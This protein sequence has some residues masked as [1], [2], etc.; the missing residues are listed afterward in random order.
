MIFIAISNPLI[1]SFLG[2]AGL[3]R[4][5]QVSIFS[6][7]LSLNKIILLSI[8]NYLIQFKPSYYFTVGEPTIITRHFTHGLTPLL[9]STAPFLFLGLIVLLN[10]LDKR[11]FQF[12]LFFIF[13]YP[14]GGAL[15]A[16]APFTSRDIIG[17]IPA[18]LLISL[19]VYHA[20][21]YLNMHFK[22]ISYIFYVIVFSAFMLNLYSFI[23]FYFAVY[24]LYSSNF[25]G[26]QF[27]AK[28]IINYFFRHEKQYD[29][30]VMSPEFNAPEIFIKFYAPHDCNNCFI[31]TPNTL[32]NPKT[33]QLFALT[34]S[35]LASH[36]QYRFQDI[37]NIIYP[38]K[39]IAFEIGKIVQ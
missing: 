9:L 18:V 17:V 37:K 35:Y 10:S 22:K 11:V 8:H 38:N 2:S 4:F 25:W 30:L 3:A 7:H 24:P 32:Y 14:L 27:G 29:Q 1:I 5:S 16:Q 28:G 36:P 23:Y 33:K 39:T 15:V 21:I 26:W 13:I 20:C 31:G 19:G 12:V 6:S 34:P